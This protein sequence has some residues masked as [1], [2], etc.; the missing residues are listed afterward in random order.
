MPVHDRTDRDLADVPPERIPAF[1]KMLGMD[2]IRAG[3]GVAEVALDLR[4]ELTNRRG[5]AHGGVITSLLDV[6]LGSAVVSGIRPEEW[7]GTVQL[8]VQF[9]EPGQ[10]AKLT[11][12][13]RMVK[14]GRHLAFAEGEIIDPQGRIVATAQGTWYVWPSRPGTGSPR[15][16]AG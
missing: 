13:G 15:A 16:D 2:R 1:N 4:Q 7:C 11:A 9:R 10:G 5:V 6:A 12:H 3:R 14:R 8:N